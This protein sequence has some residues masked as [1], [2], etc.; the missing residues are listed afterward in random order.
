LL[1]SELIPAPCELVAK[2][3]N[4]Y[5]VPGVNP[6]TVIGVPVPVPVIPPGVDIA[7]YSVIAYPPSDAGAV[8]P[9][10]AV[11]VPVFVAVP[12]VGAPGVLGF[13]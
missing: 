3:T 9:T 13:I 8:N 11:V 12:I 7:V 6:V 2:T 5:S 10:V 4:V 1:D